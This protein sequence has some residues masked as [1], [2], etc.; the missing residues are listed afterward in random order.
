MVHVRS[1]VLTLE[2]HVTWDVILSSLRKGLPTF[3]MNL[4]TFSETSM[5]LRQTRRSH[6]SQ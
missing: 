6:A 4:D 3:Q 1:L 5:H 2:S